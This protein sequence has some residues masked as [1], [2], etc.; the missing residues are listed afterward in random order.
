VAAAYFTV[1]DVVIFPNSDA[2]G[3]QGRSE[4][5][6]VKHVDED[7]NQAFAAKQGMAP[8]NAGDPWDYTND[9]DGSVG[10]VS[11]NP[12]GVFALTAHTANDFGWA[13]SGGVV[14]ED[15]IAGM[16]G[17]FA[18][19][20]DVS[21]GDN[22]ILQDLSTSAIGLGPQDHAAHVAIGYALA[23]DAG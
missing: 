17:N 5:V 15:M 9:P 13:W 12:N 16:G 21:A 1:G 14:P 19:D 22:L 18:T 20:G 7:D 23:A 8:D 6:Y 11:G 3:L 2:A 4:F 10:G